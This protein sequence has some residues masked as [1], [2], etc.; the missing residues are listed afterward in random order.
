MPPPPLPL[1]SSRSR[2]GFS[3]VEVTVALAMVAFTMTALLGSMPVAL[4]TYREAIDSSLKANILQKIVAE[5][6]QTPFDQIRSDAPEFGIERFFDDQ[7]LEVSPQEARFAVRCT[8]ANAASIFGATSSRLKPVTIE[9]GNA[10]GNGSP[11]PASATVTVFISDN[12]VRAKT[13]A[14]AGR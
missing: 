13:A 7:G 12:G 2:S 3:L 1:R 14:T 11:S 5:L 6:E 4:Q 8:I 10:S 9:I